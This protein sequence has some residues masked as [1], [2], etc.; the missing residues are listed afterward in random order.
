MPRNP[1][2]R[3]CSFPDCKAWSMKGGHLCTAHARQFAVPVRLSAIPL[4]TVHELPT[5]EQQIRDLV[6]RRQRLD[7]WLLQTVLA[8][9]ESIDLLQHS[10]LTSTITARIFRMLTRYTQIVNAQRED[11]SWIEEVYEGLAE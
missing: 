2:K 4:P 5:L 11:A 3:K 10:K 8:E 7:K 9:G 1:D 6:A